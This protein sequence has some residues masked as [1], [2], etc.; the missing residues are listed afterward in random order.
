VF[1]VLG[2]RGWNGIPSP[3]EHAAIHRYWRE[4]YGARIQAMTNDTLELVVGHS[5]R[6]T[7]AA[8]ELAREQISYNI[9]IGQGEHPTLALLAAALVDRSRW[10]FW[11][12]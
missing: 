9:D 11:F 8:F 6:T 1:A 7:A 3:E 12:D 4:R 10:Y 5:P 2:W